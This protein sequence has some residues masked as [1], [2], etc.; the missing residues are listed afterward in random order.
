MYGLIRDSLFTPKNL[1]KYRNKSGFFT[2][3]YIFLLTTLVSIGG[4]VYYF[5][6]TGNSVITEETTG[7]SL[8]SESMVCAGAAHDPDQIYALYGFSVYFMNDTETITDPTEERIVFKGN[9]IIFTSKQIGTVQMDATQVIAVSASFSEFISA[10]ASTIRFM[11]VMVLFLSNMILI[12]FVSLLGTI[13]FFRLKKFIEYKKIF[14]LVVFA[15]T[16]FSVLLTFYNLLELPDI[17]V[18][19]LMFFSYRSLFVLQRV[20]TEQTF[21]H[22]TQHIDGGGTAEPQK[23]PMHP[24]D[25]TV[26]EEETKSDPGDEDED[27][28]D[29]YA[30]SDDSK[31]DHNED[32]DQ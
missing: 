23:L 7:C 11:Q 3:I 15:M 27:E 6:Y 5:S 24:E 28:E 14:K 16:P 32:Q 8:V 10:F 1:L 17:L 26:P 31:P 20:L 22:L 12:L 18:V 2:F 29:P 30:P 21:L 13:P 9:T 25:E 4:M 19:I